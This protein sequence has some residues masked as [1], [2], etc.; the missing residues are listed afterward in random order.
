MHAKSTADN[1]IC[2]YEEESLLK[3]WK[4]TPFWKLN[5]DESV[6]KILNLVLDCKIQMSLG[7]F[8]FLYGNSKLA[9]LRNDKINNLYLLLTKRKFF[10]KINSL[11][12][13]MLEIVLKSCIYTGSNDSNEAL[14][15]FSYFDDDNQNKNV[16]YKLITTFETDPDSLRHLLDS[17]FSA[18]S[19]YYT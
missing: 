10:S 1:E 14:A 3:Q 18:I 16:L 13:E 4:I 19:R 8:D 15:P 7:D 17:L 5:V 12:F 9:F 2:L 6:T 11:T